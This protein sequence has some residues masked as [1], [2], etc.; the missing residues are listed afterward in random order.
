MTNKETNWYALENLTYFSLLLFAISL[1]IK[2]SI[3]NNLAVVILILAWLFSFV[4]GSIHKPNNSFLFY[5][6]ISVYALHLI[7]VSY[8]QDVQEAISQLEK[9]ALLLIFPLVLG[10]QLPLTEKR[11][12]AILL[13]FAF[14][15][16]LIAILCITTT[17]Y[18]N[19]KN[20]I[21]LEVYNAWYFSSENLTNRFGF[22]PNYM[23][24]YAVFS[25]AI[26]SRHV[27]SEINQNN[28]VK[29]IPYFIIILFLIVFTAL[30]SARMQMIVLILLLISATIYYSNR[31]SN[32][33][34]SISLT[35]I[36]ICTVIGS[37]AYSPI[38]KEKFKGL[39]GV[40]VDNDNQKFSADL[41][42]QKWSSALNIIA[43]SPIVGVGTGDMQ[44]EL[45]KQYK[46]KSY[47]I[48]Y[49]SEYNSH[50]QYL[51]FAGRFGLI[52]LSIFIIS[53]FYPMLQAFRVKNTLFIGF[54]LIIIFSFIPEVVLS[55]NKGVAFYAFFTSLFTFS[56]L[57]IPESNL[58]NS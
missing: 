47:D 19:I 20:G 1:P 21:E 30:L 15:T 44:S 38:L 28:Y 11:L 7:G 56:Y 13:A 6:F 3:L 4:K 39:V 25:I 16:T 48:A 29:S 37:I 41:R 35:V 18:F 31:L 42:L 33:L 54:Y 32:P 40:Y 46:D 36:I 51:D 5:T 14:T 2:Y 57:R 12:K 22:H 27:E 23:A 50:N 17:F 26:F 43:E 8:S 58:D 52:G 10:T 9:K 24:M 45:Q 53:L 55:L 34:Y 49:E